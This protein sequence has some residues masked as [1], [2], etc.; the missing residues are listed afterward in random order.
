MKKYRAII[1]EF[2][3]DYNS[4]SGSKDIPVNSWE[5]AEAYC[6]EHSWSG[7]DYVVYG[8]ID[9]SIQ[10]GYFSKKEFKDE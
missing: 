6:N 10:K 4:F 8:L 1:H 7:H 3:K 9:D 5:E 2:D